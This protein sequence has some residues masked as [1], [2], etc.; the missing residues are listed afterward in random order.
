MKHFIRFVIF[1]AVAAM[2]LS[3]FSVSPRHTDNTV[4]PHQLK[5][6]RKCSDFIDFYLLRCRS[7]VDTILRFQIFCNNFQ[8]LYLLL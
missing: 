8:D 7:I 4:A 1:S 2:L 5:N 3:V 6:H